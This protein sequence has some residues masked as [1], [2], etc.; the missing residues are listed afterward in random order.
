M[1]LE[2]T[3]TGHY[4]I[5]VNNPREYACT[6]EPSFGSKAAMTHFTST[7]LNTVV[8]FLMGIIYH[9]GLV[10]HYLSVTPLYLFNTDRITPGLVLQCCCKKSRS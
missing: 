6:Q 9:H 8:Q 2:V 5:L 1:E 10:S 7:Y 4:Y 3:I